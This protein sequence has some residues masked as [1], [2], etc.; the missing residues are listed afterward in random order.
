[1]R[2][3]RQNNRQPLPWEREEVNR[4][5]PVMCGLGLSTSCT[6]S[7]VNGLFHAIGSPLVG[8]RVLLFIPSL[9]KRGR[10]VFQYRQCH[11]HSV[12]SICHPNLSFLN[13]AFQLHAG[14]GEC[15]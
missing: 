15:G 7:A 1:M 3:F 4:R 9:S 14:L 13:S 8:M 6:V 12:H 11:V 2:T 10:S 5:K